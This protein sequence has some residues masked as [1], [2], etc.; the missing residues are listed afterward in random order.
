M[1]NTASQIQDICVTANKSIESVKDC[2]KDI[3]EFMENDVTM[4][5]RD[6]TGMA[7]SYGEDLRNIQN[8]ITSIEHTSIEF[9]HSMGVIKEQ[10][11]H[12][13]AASA[14]NELG[15][16]DIISKNDLTTDT[17]DKIMKVAEDNSNN[18]REI[19]DIIERFK[20]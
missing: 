18:A 13:S 4:Q 3:I 12:V 17:A 7:R 11:D 10:V 8:S 6:F 14:D 2:F 5:L 15:V 9:T 16:N 20:Q 19:N 1:T